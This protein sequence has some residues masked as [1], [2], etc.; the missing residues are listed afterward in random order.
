MKK[1]IFYIKDIKNSLEKI[2]KYT[3]SLSYEDFIDDEKTRDAVERNLEIIGEA[4]KKL[5][6]ELKS[7]HPN[8]PFK[9]I[10]GMRDKLIH[11]YFGIDYEIV[12][13]TIQNKLPEFFKRIDEIIKEI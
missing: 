5:S 7:R 12:W 13:H 9:Q 2:F 1:D 11:D 6:N 4:V 8:I 3:N 10:A